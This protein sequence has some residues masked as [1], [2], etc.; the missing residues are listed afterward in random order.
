MSDKACDFQSL[1]HKS[2]ASAIVYLVLEHE[3]S[4]R[5]FSFY[6]ATSECD[7]DVNK[8]FDCEPLILGPAVNRMGEVGP[9]EQRSHSKK[10]EFFRP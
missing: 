5:S 7:S 8:R 10:G 2:L 9:S 1:I 3:S 4:R 6:K